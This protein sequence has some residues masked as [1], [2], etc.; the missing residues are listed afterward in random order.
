MLFLCYNDNKLENEVIR[1]NGNVFIIMMFLTV[2][3]LMLFLIN[4]VREK[5]ARYLTAITA[6]VSAWFVGIILDA[7]TDQFMSFRTLLPILAMGLCII[8]V[9]GKNKPE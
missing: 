7:A 2:F 5:Q 8:N 6:T 9:I 1:M 3:L 4:S